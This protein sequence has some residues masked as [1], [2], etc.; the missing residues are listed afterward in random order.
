MAKLLD[1][2]KAYIGGLLKGTWIAGTD[3]LPI[4]D[5]RVSTHLFGPA[6]G[7]HDGLDARMYDRCPDIRAC[8]ERGAGEPRGPTTPMRRVSVAPT[9]QAAS[10]RRAR[11]R[12]EPEPDQAG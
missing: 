8:G 5:L 9:S 2:L 10:P 7:H 3:E 4:A 6:L 11:Q 1:K 12:P